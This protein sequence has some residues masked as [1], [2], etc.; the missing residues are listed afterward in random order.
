MVIHT[1]TTHTLPRDFVKVVVDVERKI[2]AAG[3]E[4]HIDCADELMNDG[5]SRTDLWGANV[6]L[7]KN[8]IDFISLINIRPAEGNHSMEILLSAVKNKVEAVIRNLLF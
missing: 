6:Y 3:C 2:L 8:A 1:K 5:S 7:D 4:L